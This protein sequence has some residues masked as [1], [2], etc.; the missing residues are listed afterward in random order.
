[1]SNLI[2]CVLKNYKYLIKI[3]YFFISGHCSLNQRWK[4]NK[5]IKTDTKAYALRVNEKE[6]V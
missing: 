1:M 5:I 3:T 2:K 6:N 4:S